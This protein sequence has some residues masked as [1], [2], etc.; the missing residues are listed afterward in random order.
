[1]KSFLRS[2]VALALVGTAVTACGSS[3]SRE[4]N[5]PFVVRCAQGGPCKVGDIGPGGGVVFVGG[6]KP[7]DL[8][9]EAADVN[10]YGTHEE[11]LK[12]ADEFTFGGA[13]DWE[14]PTAEDLEA[15][16]EQ[17]DAFAC[18]EATDCVTAYADDVYWS[19]DQDENGNV[20]AKSFADGTVSAVDPTKTHYYRPVRNFRFGD[21]SF[22][23]TTTTSAP[24]T[25][26]SE[27]A[28]VTTTEEPTTTTEE[29]TTTTVGPTT[30]EVAT[31]T[32][33][34]AATTT[35]EEPTT[36]TVAP[37][38]TEAPATTVAPTTTL[39]ATST[40][41]P[42]VTVA[43]CADGGPCNVGDT[44]PAG[45]IILLANFMLNEPPTLIEVAP[46][47][48]FGNAQ[49]A[50]V[51][52]DKLSYGGFDDWVVPNLSQLLTMRR[53]RARF[54]CATGTRCT[55]G[56]NPSTYWAAITVNPTHTV[57]FAG[58]GDPQPVGPRTSHFIRPIR[59]IGVLGPEGAVLPPLE[60]A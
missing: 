20:V 16:Y 6:G 43:S 3:N 13:T 58:T 33:E 32:T 25:T 8:M 2:I 28:T 37:T 38:T 5:I 23:A 59:V 52:V 1:M 55:T 34:V 57:S 15:M 45:G 18:A 44:G 60:E 54:S 10:G 46:T 17:A 56:F 9:W 36:T 22:S 27:A 19:F 21:I 14:L 29:P 31:T 39:P 40:T 48:W 49:K 51:Y 4:R 35:T 41:A 53:E 7:N 42:K 24:A 12:D 11:A 26:T 50:K 30:T 47:T